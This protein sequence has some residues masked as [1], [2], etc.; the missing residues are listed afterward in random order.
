MLK[1]IDEGIEE[2]R[3]FAYYKIFPFKYL[4]IA[5]E[6]N[7][8][9]KVEKPDRHPLNQVIKVNIISSK[10]YQNHA[11]PGIMHWEGKITFKYLTAKFIIST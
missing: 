3:L 1:T 8:N 7:S 6:E 11:P 10:T 5:K 2:T 4:L 9:F